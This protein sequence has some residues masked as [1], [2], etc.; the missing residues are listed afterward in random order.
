[1]M[2]S[3]LS[4]LPPQLW[5]LPVAIE[6]IGADGKHFDL[7]ADE[8]IRTTLAR[9]AGVH[10][11]V[12]LKASFD[13]RRHGAGGLRVA[14]RVSATVGQTCVVTLEP[15]LNAVEEDVDLIFLPGAAAAGPAKAEAEVQDGPEPLVDGRVDLGAIAI[16]FFML[17]ID[18]YPRQPGAEFQPP[19]AEEPAA[20][21]FAALAALKDGPDQGGG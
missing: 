1:M 17:G 14:G 9:I 21:P 13:V 12:R 3:R 18:P 11:V 16:E 19:R 10:E 6:E 15:L 8:G 20:G 4:K 7:V 5:R 2:A